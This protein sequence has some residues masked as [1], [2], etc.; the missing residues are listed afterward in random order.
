MFIEVTELVTKKATFINVNHIVYY[1]PRGTG[2][3]T[4]LMLHDSGRLDVVE[5]SD[6]FMA[7]LNV[8]T[9]KKFVED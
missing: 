8:I 5:D 9:A 2:K 1:R 4:V 6:Y 3:P 7:Q